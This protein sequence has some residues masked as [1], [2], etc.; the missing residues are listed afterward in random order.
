M[1]KLT[2]H[3]RQ[4]HTVMWGDLESFVKQVY[5]HDIEIAAMEEAN[6]GDNLSFFV[7]STMV[8]SYDREEFT[9]WKTTGDF[10]PFGTATILNFL[11]LDGY[12]PSGYYMVIIDY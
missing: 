1:P 8:G 11:M 7:T 9:R 12:I 10:W 2:M 5:G 4:V 6:N 3:D